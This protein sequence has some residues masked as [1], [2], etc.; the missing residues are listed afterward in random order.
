MAITKAQV[1]E[2]V[3]IN[4]DEVGVA[5]YYSDDA[6]NDTFL[7]IYDDVVCNC[8][9]F[10]KSVDV[11]WVE[12]RVYYNL[13]NTITDYMIAAAIFDNRN[14]RWLEGRSV[15]FFENL[16]EKWETSRGTPVYFAVLN[17]QYVAFYS[18]YA[19]TEGS[20]KLFYKYR[21]PE[22]T[23]GDDVAITDNVETLLVDGMTADLL[24]QSHEFTKAGIF[25]RRY[26]TSIAQERKLV[27][28]RISPDRL[29]RFA[30]QD[31]R[32]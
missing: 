1:I 30:Q 18:H 12:N 25:M 17:Y 31:P 4:L 32:G 6:L 11:N 16:S 24:E 14:N 19:T 13:Y 9:P 27:A 28:G 22:L 3:R 29:I 5:T 2:R 10:E 23:S 8:L 15:R 20:F 21:P 7:D 26:Y